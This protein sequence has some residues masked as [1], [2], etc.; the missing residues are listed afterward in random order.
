MNTQYKLK[1]VIIGV[2]D[3]KYYLYEELGVG[4]SCIA[5]LASPI[6]DE[7]KKF[8]VKVIINEN[9]RHNPFSCF[10]R[11]IKAL[12]QLSDNNNEAS[13]NII[14][15]ENYK[16]NAIL[17]LF[18]SSQDKSQ[19]KHN[20]MSENIYQEDPHDEHQEEVL[21]TVDYICLGLAEKGELF[22]YL[23]YYSKGFTEDIAR[24]LFTQILNGVNYCHQIGF[25]H[26]DLKLDNI[27]FDSNWIIKISDFGLSATKM[28]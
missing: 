6:N 28:G 23:K 20:D 21:E 27:L 16:S 5:Y 1:K 19:E 3:D 2:L 18:N 8:A 25:V 22:D 12:S 10:E 14:Y 17:K 7:Y 4:A 11:E 13:K 15:M 26:R 9:V 24:F